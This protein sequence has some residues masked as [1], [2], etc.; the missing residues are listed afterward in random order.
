MDLYCC[1]L[2]SHLESIIGFTKNG[3]QEKIYSHSPAKCLGLKAS[4]PF[5][6]QHK[7]NQINVRTKFYTQAIK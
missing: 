3:T 6:A 4:S 2:W 5:L 7:S 1:T